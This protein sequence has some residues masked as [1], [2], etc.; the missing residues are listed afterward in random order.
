VKVIGSAARRNR[1]DELR[2]L[3]LNQFAIPAVAGVLDG[4]I[5]EANLECGGHAT[6]LGGRESGGTAAALQII[7]GRHTDQ[8][9]L[10]FQ[11]DLS[12]TGQM[13][14]GIALE[15]I[16]HLIPVVTSQGR[17]AVQREDPHRNVL[18]GEVSPD[19]QIAIAQRLAVLEAGDKNAAFQG[20]GHSW[21]IL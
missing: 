13:N 17:A 9:N 1:S 19:P 4:L 11:L 10:S 7:Y 21:I 15:D 8:R 12:P 5:G 6:A 2:D 16:E 3:A 18:P 14:P 20:Q